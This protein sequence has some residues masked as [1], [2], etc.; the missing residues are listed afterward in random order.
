[1]VE[2]NDPLSILTKKSH[3]N[4]RLNGFFSQNTEGGQI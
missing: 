3:S 1:M 2:S 4:T